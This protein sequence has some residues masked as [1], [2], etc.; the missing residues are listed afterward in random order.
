MGHS[1]FGGIAAVLTIVLAACASQEAPGSPPGPDRSAEWAAGVPFSDFLSA[2]TIN[3]A[4]WQEN[5]R[6]GVP[7]D[8][9]AAAREV[10]GEWRLLVLA[11]S[12]CSDAVHSVPFLAALA[13]SVAGLELRLLRVAGQEELFRGHERGD[14]ARH[15]L[16]LVLDGGGQERAGWVERPLELASWIE[17]RRGTIPDDDI[18]LYRQGWYEGNR[19]RG[20]M[21]EVLA[22][23]EGARSGRIAD[24]GP[25]PV[26]TSGGDI[27]PCPSPE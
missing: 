14:R 20:A 16:V 4:L 9:V 24:T 12:W 18:R 17:A 25:P 3:L 21:T 11:E 23:I 13:D 7:G 5:A 10:G 8:I 22:L 2:D 15:P 26:A 27:T 19:G 1:T 6:R